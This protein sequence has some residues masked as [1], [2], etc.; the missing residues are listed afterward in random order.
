MCTTGLVVIDNLCQL[1][2]RTG[3]I[4]YLFALALVLFVIASAF[5][6]WKKVQGLIAPY[7][8]EMRM[9]EFLLFCRYYPYLPDKLKTALRDEFGIEPPDGG[10]ITAAEIAGMWQAIGHG[11]LSRAIIAAAILIPLLLIAR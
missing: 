3:G 4:G 6:A 10:K 2:L 5:L 9:A 11:T 1:A 8:N 7:R